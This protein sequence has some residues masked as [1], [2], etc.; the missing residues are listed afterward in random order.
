MG[1]FF[2]DCRTPFGT[3]RGQ[4]LSFAGVAVAHAALLGLIAVAVPA[5]RLADLTRPFTARVIESKPEAPP[6]PPKQPP[7]KA[8]PT[9]LP[10]L[11]AN[12]P[13]PSPETATFT[14]PIQPPAPVAAPPIVAA[15]VAAPP[16]IVAARFDA[17]YLHN[18]KPVYPVAS[19]RLSEEGKV[20]LRVRVSADGL[21]EHVEIKHTSG[22]PRLDGAALE[23]VTRWRF[24]PAR[25]SEEAIAAWVLVPITFNLES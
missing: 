1:L 15:A 7:K 25:R 8:E 19:R 22:F 11:A 24:V 20:V 13:S 17:D 12:T 16:T 21:P 9:P 4:R 14:V 3:P 2:P 6:P 10:I 18:P 23:T 5:E